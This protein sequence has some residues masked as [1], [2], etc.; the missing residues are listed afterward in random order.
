MSIY[1]GILNGKRRY[2]ELVEVGVGEGWRV[3]LQNFWRETIFIFV[4][5]YFWF[6]TSQP[7]TLHPT[8][9]Y[10][11]LYYD[12]YIWYGYGQVRVGVDGQIFLPY[13]VVPETFDLWPLHP[14]PDIS[15]H[16]R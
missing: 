5:E 16:I 14:T 8:L 7:C 1:N 11:V 6:I 4:G 3:N 13:Y 15:L 10:C 9:L 12:T 2:G